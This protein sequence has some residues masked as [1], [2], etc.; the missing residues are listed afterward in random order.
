MIGMEKEQLEPYELHAARQLAAEMWSKVIRP[1]DTVVD[2]TLGN[3]HDT[4]ILAG[5]VGVSGHVIGFDIQEEAVARTRERLS[6]AGLEARC[7]LH[8][9]SHE[10]MADFI[11]AEV[12]CVVFN[13]GWLPGWDKS[14][15]T[16]WESTRTAVL[17]ALDHLAPLGMLTVC[18]YPGHAAGEEERCRLL[19]LLASLPPQVYNV[20]HQRFLN[21]GAGAPECFAVQR[22]RRRNSPNQ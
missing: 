5:L 7:E 22:Q 20:L 16:H 13:L 15:T 6:S 10:H 9:L 18:V 4:C 8:A 14:I 11:P 3:G 12:Q 21:A 1:G 19:E 2:A 17:A